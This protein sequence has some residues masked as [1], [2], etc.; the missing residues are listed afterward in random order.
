MAGA[1]SSAGA[2]AASTLFSVRAAGSACR[3]C[4][5]TARFELVP[6]A[7]TAS[8]RGRRDTWPASP[9][10]PSASLLRVCAR[11]SLN[12]ASS[13]SAVATARN[14][15]SASTASAFFPCWSSASPSRNIAARNSSVSE[16]LGSA[17]SGCNSSTALA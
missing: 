12:C 1:A 17:A 7:P 9:A 14:F 11:A 8:R 16:T 4:N 2:F 10:P 3:P 5:P 6:A 15:L 13:L